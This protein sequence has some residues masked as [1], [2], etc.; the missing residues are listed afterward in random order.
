MRN[1]IKS[2]RS[3][4]NFCPF[5]WFSVPNQHF[6]SRTFVCPWKKPKNICTAYVIVLL[7]LCTGEIPPVC[8]ITERNLEFNLP[9][10][11]C[12]TEINTDLPKL[13]ICRWISDRNWNYKIPD[14]FFVLILIR[15][16]SKLVNQPWVGST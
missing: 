10:S 6:W 5:L 15:N 14:F 9:N 4:K 7:I 12:N 11:T 13:C 1:R 16:S 3:E 8:R 2:I